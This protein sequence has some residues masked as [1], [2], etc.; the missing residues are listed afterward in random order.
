VSPPAVI[1]VGGGLAGISAALA[2]ADAGAEVVLVERRHRLGG[3][4]WSFRRNGLWFDNGQH[5][6]L[7]CCTA[8]RDLLQR[9]GAAD[10]V[11]LQD[12]L[13]IPV[14]APGGDRA[15]IGRNRLPS[16][17]HLAPSLLR[18][19]HLSAGDRARLA[20]PA[21]A[22]RRLDP[23]DP[24]L[25]RITF[26]E[27]LATMGQRPAAI[28]R[29]WN[30]IILPTVNVAAA[31]ASLA[32]AV[33]VF[34]TGLLDRT[35]AG[36]VGWSAVPLVQLHGD[37]GERALAGAGVETVLGDRVTSVSPEP[38]GR[39]LVTTATRELRAGSVIVTTPPQVAR[40]VLP[41]GVVG[42]VE[43][44]GAS[45]IVNVHLVLDRKVT[46]L[47]MAAA[48]GSPVQFVFDRTASAGATSGQCLSVSL[49]GADAYVGQRPEDLV[50]SFADA[51]GDLFPAARRANLV[52]G[53][54][55]REHTATFRGIPGTA[56]L[57]PP[58]R[59]AVPGLF[60]AGNW[61]RTG[62]PATMESAVRSGVAAASEALGSTP[63]PAGPPRPLQETRS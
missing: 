48:V 50:R 11:V 8:Y 7:R 15:T 24:A 30:L 39:L 28:E 23:E 14:L 43:G 31:E 10:Q 41:P 42:P 53:V 13:R 12:R 60:L 22:L 40:Q 34:R 36:D 55:T 52:D 17:L 32:L 19:R 51:L 35:D 54:V 2:A 58:N 57:R 62:W 1:V 46:D 29:L 33:K 44:L 45:P 4:T 16:P 38:D 26:G 20:R 18:Y 27:W 49:S 63:A 25:D 56:A 9:I 37:N 47:E 59:T 6:F 61:C 21:L 3:L 5:V